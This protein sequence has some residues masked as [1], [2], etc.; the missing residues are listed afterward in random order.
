MNMQ[1]IVIIFALLAA[2]SLDLAWAGPPVELTGKATQGGLLVGRA[3]G[4]R[5]V[6]L[7]GRAVRV[8]PAGVFLVGFDRDAPPTAELVATGPDGD[9]TRRVIDVA[10]REYR[11]QRVDGLPDSKVTPPDDVLERIR[12]EGARVSAARS[13]DDPRTDFLDGFVWPLTGRISGVYGSQRILN[14]APRRPHYG[15]DVAAATGTPV[16]A[17]ADAVVRLAEPDLYFSGGTLIMDHGHGL[18]STFIHLSRLL[19]EEGQ[20]VRRGEVVAE[21]GATGRAT[22]PHLDWRMNLFETRIDPQLVTAP[23]P[24]P[25]PRR[26]AP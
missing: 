1:P 26:A 19:V 21:V 10:Q 14:G 18:T 6:E 15:V 11:I 20:T 23:M 3:P 5:A 9:V 17:P 2:F 13:V 25:T 4:A 16:V 8:S 24:D 22:G 12:A 7:D